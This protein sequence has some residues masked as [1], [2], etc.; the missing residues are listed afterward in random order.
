MP[1]KKPSKLL[2]FFAAFFNVFWYI[3]LFLIILYALALVLCVPRLPENRFTNFVVPVGIDLLKLAEDMEKYE[4]GPEIVRVLGY[5]EVH[6]A[7]KAR[8]VF[9]YD[10][11]YTLAIGILSL[12]CIWQ[13]RM[14]LRT[15]RDGRLF[16]RENPGRIRK[17]A[18][19][20]FAFV[21]LESGWDWW[22]GKSYLHYV[23]LPSPSFFWTLLP[24]SEAIIVTLF[25]LLIAQVF[26]EGV[27][28]Q[29]EQELTV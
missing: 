5:S 13:W 18:L 29:E 1:A 14:L 10:A 11:V 24:A 8:K 9:F 17:V 28:M 25:I 6:L 7:I 21:P 20:T 26:D 2:C 12:A 19:L 27:K 15:V 16:A 4:N 23:S 3:V 22:L